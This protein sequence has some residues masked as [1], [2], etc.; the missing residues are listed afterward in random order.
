MK[1][2]LTNLG[3]EISAGIEDAAPPSPA[4]DADQVRPRRSYVYAHLDSK[5]KIFYIGKAT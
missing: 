3:I 5:G 1:A 4:P 2:R